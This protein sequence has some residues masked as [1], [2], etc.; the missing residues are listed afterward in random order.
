MDFWKY[1]FK[2]FRNGTELKQLSLYLFYDTILRLYFAAFR[3]KF[4]HCAYDT[5][6]LSNKIN[7]TFESCVYFAQKH[8]CLISRL[9]SMLWIQDNGKYKYSNFI[10]IT[11][12]YQLK[13][14]NYSVSNIDFKESYPILQ[15][16]KQLFVEI[17][18]RIAEFL[19]RTLKI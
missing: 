4:F 3:F 16:S 11:S 10:R 14:L 9:H 15:N 12:S 6:K 5:L 18:V 2:I 17:Y 19:S 7:V 1:F 8:G 13:I